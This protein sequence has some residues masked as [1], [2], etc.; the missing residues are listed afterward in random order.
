MQFAVLAEE[1]LATELRGVDVPDA[2]RRRVP[3]AGVTS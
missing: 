2:H 3:L 1:V